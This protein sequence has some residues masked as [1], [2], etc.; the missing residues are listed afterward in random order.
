MS[1]ERTAKAKQSTLLNVTGVQRSPLSKLCSPLGELCEASY[2][3]V[4][5]PHHSCR[6]IGLLRWQ[7]HQYIFYMKFVEG[8]AFARLLV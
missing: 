2:V 4:P 8:S 5:K 6:L 3:R 7:E 1:V